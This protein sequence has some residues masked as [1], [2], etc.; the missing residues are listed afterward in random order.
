MAGPLAKEPDEVDRVIRV[1]VRESHVRDAF[2]RMISLCQAVCDPGAAIDQ[3]PHRWSID[4]N[5]S[6]DAIS[7]RRR[8]CRAEHC[9]AHQR[10]RKTARLY[11]SKSCVLSRTR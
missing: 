5:P 6:L 1:E 8:A 3:E 10:P 9:Y 11:D 7:I 4:E 2:P